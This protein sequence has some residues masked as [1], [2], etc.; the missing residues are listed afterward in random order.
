MLIRRFINSDAKQVA[1]MIALTLRTINIKDYTYDYIENLVAKIT[2]IYLIDKANHTHMYVVTIDDKIVGCGAIGPYYDKTD[3][4]CLFT[5]FVSPH[6][7]GLGIGKKIIDTLEG[8][9]YFIRAKRIEVPASITAH[10]FYLKLG[11][12]YKNDNKTLASDDLI[13]MEKFR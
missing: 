8:D 1:D 9:E 4:S 12:G 10:K 2:P 11:Y 6:C 13:Y 7:Q 3:E 5:I